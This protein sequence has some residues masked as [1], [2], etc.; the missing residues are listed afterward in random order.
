MSLNTFS[1]LSE[2]EFSAMVTGFRP[3]PVEREKSSE[4]VMSKEAKLEPLPDSFDRREKGAR[5]NIKKSMP[6][7]YSKS[8][9]RENNLVCDS[10]KLFNSLIPNFVR[11]KEPE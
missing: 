10:P 9:I 7:F 6:P 2:K 1:D 11:C 8:Q 4:L 3:G 5:T